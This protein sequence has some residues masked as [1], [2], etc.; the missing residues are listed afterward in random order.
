[1]PQAASLWSSTVG[2]KIVMAVTGL[3]LVLFVLFHAF[4]NIK[5]YLGPAVFNHYAEGL[6]TFGAPFLGRE[7]LLWVVRAVLIVSVV[8]HIWAGV[9][10]NLR[11]ARMREREYRR[12]DY[13]GFA[14]AS[15]TMVWGGLVI[16]GFVTYHL[17]DLTLGTA[18]PSF[19]PGDAYHNFVASFSRWP[20]SLAYVV[21]M[22]PL[23]LHLYHGFWSM[24]QTLGWNNERYNVYR[25]PTAAALAIAIVLVNISFPLAVLA[26]IVR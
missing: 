21:A 23:G 14:W 9:A 6:R 1:M 25:R 18:N 16:F 12:F 19:V 15:K 22:I 4:G 10:L 7:W 8:L 20:V 26:G 2:K 11:S 17:M 5:V 24:F 3:I 13:L